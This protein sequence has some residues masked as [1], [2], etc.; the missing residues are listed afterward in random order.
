MMAEI[1]HANAGA[2][3]VRPSFRVVGSRAK[4]TEQSFLTEGIGLTETNPAFFDHSD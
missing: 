4:G 3:P 1:A 2:R